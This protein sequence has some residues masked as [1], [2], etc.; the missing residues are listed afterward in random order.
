MAATEREA[1]RQ[2]QPPHALPLQLA[3]PG[4]AAARARSENFPVAMGLLPRR[5]REDLLALYAFARLVDDL[6][7]ESAGDRLALLDELDDQL[8]SMAGG[9]ATHPVVIAIGRTVRRHG[10][11]LGPFRRL[12]AANRQDQAIRRY[13]TFDDLLQYCTLSAN[14]VGE[15][16]LGVFGHATPERVAWS[17]SVC[18]SLQVIEHLQDVGEDFARGRIYLPTEDLALFGVAEAALA[19]SRAQPALRRLVAW[20]A[21]RAVELLAPGPALVSSLSGW[22]R[23]AVAGFVGGGRATLESLARCGYD[24][25]SQHP[26]PVRSTIA[27]HTLSLLVT[28]GQR[29]SPL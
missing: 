18:S 11:G 25:L 20:E 29:W 28:P 27:R 4:A 23:V 16:V 1:V 3:A 9:S 15:V 19:E 8:T 21:A 13:A 2:P 22:G 14:P 7:D 5:L 26:G 24:S 17:D 10:L 12:V 6:G